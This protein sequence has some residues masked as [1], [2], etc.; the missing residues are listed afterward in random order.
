[1]NDIARCSSRSLMVVALFLIVSCSGK[2]APDPNAPTNVPSEINLPGWVLQPEVEEGIAAAQCVQFSGN[3]SL[4][5]Q[6]I[7]AKGRAALA[8]Q[9]N[10]RAQVMDQVFQDRIETDE[11][12][13]SG[14]V[15]QNVSR[16]VTDQLLIGSKLIR[17][18]FGDI[19]DA[20]YICG[21]VAISPSE[22][23]RLFESIV[24][25]EDAPTTNV[26]DKDILYQE[27]KAYKAQQDLAQAIGQ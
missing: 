12:S 22:T 25:S 11:K 6:E 24:S 23:E 1:M 16:Q 17:T 9:V 26:Q 15:F 27:F 18:D 14:S 5:Q 10:L 3:I 4:D 8:Q 7:T 13:T 21:L 20:P 19:N 2:D